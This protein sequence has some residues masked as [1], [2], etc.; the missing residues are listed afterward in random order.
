LRLGFLRR[1]SH[2]WSNIWC[3]TTTRQRWSNALSSRALRA[4]A[5]TAASNARAA[6]SA[7]RAGRMASICARVKVQGYAVIHSSLDMRLATAKPHEAPNANTNATRMPAATSG[8]H[9]CQRSVLD[10]CR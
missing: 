4:P 5:I 6:S 8:A 1:S 3:S 9:G 2:T 10:G 7:V